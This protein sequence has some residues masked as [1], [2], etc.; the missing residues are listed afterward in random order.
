M[1]QKKKRERKITGKFV[2]AE[3]F[4]RTIEILQHKTKS[5]ASSFLGKLRVYMLNDFRSSLPIYH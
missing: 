3:R 5:E 2:K 1:D 4:K